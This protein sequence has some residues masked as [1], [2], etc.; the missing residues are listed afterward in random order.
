LLWVQGSLGG[1]WIKKSLNLTSWEAASD[2]VTGWT[3]SG[4]VGVVR[5]E[6]PPLKD[7]IEKF[8]AD[9]KAQ[10]L[11][12]ETIRKY[13]TFLDRRFLAWCEAKGYRLLKQITPPVLT[14]FRK[15]WDDSVLPFLRAHEMD[16]RESRACAQTAKGGYHADA[17]VHGRT[18]EK[19]CWPRATCIAATRCASRDSSW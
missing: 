5:A 13:E 12:W 8:I 1:E 4:Q 14:D 19:S 17:P 15:T 10:Q 16:P 11:N 6:I 3:A 9:A 7:A 2:L 18:D